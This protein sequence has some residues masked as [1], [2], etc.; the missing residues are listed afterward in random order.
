MTRRW[1]TALLLVAACGRP[2]PTLAPGPVHE[3]V[4]EPAPM[5]VQAPIAAPVP[6]PA[7]PP[8]ELPAGTTVGDLL[9]PLPQPVAPLADASHA[10]LAMPK[11]GCSD[12]G[13]EGAALVKRVELPL[14]PKAAGELPGVLEVCLF[15]KVLE[16]ATP[17]GTGKQFI[18]IA[19]W[20][21][22]AVQQTTFEPLQHAPETLP[23][24]RQKAGHDA[25]TWGT[26]IATGHPQMPVLA[27]VSGRFLDGELGEVVDYQ[28]EARLL[29][30]DGKWAPF[31]QRSFAT[32]DLAHLDALCAGKADASPA[33]RAAGALQAAC[34]RHDALAPGAAKAANERLT[35]RAKRLKG[36]GDAGDAE[37]D[38][39]PQSLWLRDA[40]KA[41][42][43]GNGH[44]AFLL[45]LRVDAVCG[46]AATE[47][48][49]LLGEVLAAGQI[50]PQKPKPAQTL[51][52][53]CEP[54]PDKP[55]P[56]R[57]APK[58]P[59]AKTP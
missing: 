29:G 36:A 50:A 21:G 16:K 53:L 56:R 7:A 19:A 4:R 11:I 13:P 20:P 2:A 47:A 28:R 49:A 22:D 54:L 18:A 6:E 25:V 10:A 37:R 33:D 46:E 3:P 23:P 42:H 35:L 5:P 48:H 34:D 52:D 59:K 1:V 45:A 40:K 31:A 24:E 15:S 58:E 38:A 17:A 55:A 26:L 43:K 32:V 39:D 44:E 12:L 41:L 27:V 57:V 9:P 51:V 30:Q 14:A 8:L